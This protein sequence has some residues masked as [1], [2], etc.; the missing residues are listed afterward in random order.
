M[1]SESAPNYNRYWATT[2]IVA[3]VTVPHSHVP[4]V[5]QIEVLQHWELVQC[6]WD[7]ACELHDSDDVVSRTAA[8]HASEG[9]DNDTQGSQVVWGDGI[10][11]GSRAVVDAHADTVQRI[12]GEPMIISILQQA[13][14][15]AC[16]LAVA[17]AD[18]PDCY[19]HPVQPG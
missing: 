19:L 17:A 1:H 4:V 3:C 9:L 10:D 16:V 6:Y 18:V 11:A 7:A 13:T 14:G 2:A 15:P 8:K 12:S 5:G